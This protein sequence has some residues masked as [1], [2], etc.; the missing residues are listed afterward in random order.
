MNGAGAVVI[1]HFASCWVGVTWFGMYGEPFFCGKSV[2]GGVGVP[3]PGT[4]QLLTND[5]E[6]G[7]L[8]FA[9]A[10]GAQPKA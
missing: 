9:T 6:A 5:Y 10:D 4:L 1:C 8:S 7:V 2:P 3:P